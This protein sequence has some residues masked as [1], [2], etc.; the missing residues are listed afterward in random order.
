[1]NSSAMRTLVSLFDCYMVVTKGGFALS[2]RLK[3]NNTGYI[4]SVNSSNK[5]NPQQETLCCP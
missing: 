3:L 4:P 2:A 5:N 1:M